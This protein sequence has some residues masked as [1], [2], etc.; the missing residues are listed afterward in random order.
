MRSAETMPR[1]SP[2]RP[3]LAPASPAARRRAGLAQVD[4]TQSAADAGR[5]AGASAAR[6]AGS[7]RAAA[8]GACRSTEAPVEPA[9][10]ARLRRRAAQALR[11]GR[12][13]EAERALPRARA[14][15]TPSSAAPHANL[16]VIYRQAGKLDEAVGRA[17]AGRS[18]QPAP[19]DLPQP[20]RHHL[21][22]AGP[23]REGARRLREGDRARRRLRR[24]A[25]EPRHP[26]RPVPVAT[27]SARSSCT[28]A[29]SRCRRAATRR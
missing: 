21:S 3:P 6:R 25:S 11:A 9:D 20:A 29:I 22:P 5:R 12:I 13:D 17:R 7:R 4:R 27:A 28:T 2:L 14:S 10:A 19:A 16:G 15:R 23:V 24:A 26:A 1:A 18:S 8:A